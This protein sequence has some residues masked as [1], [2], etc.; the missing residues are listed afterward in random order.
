VKSLFVIEWAEAAMNY[1]ADRR[2]LIALFRKQIVRVIENGEPMSH[3]P[4]Q[5]DT[6]GNVRPRP[7]V[8][9]LTAEHSFSFL[10]KLNY[11]CSLSG[12][13]QPFGRLCAERSKWASK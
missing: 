6:I 12:T 7:N 10:I 1:P 4:F 3:P 8:R 5:A 2:A 13:N 9:K 11:Y